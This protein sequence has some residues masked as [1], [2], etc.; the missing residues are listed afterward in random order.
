VGSPQQVLEKTLSFQEYFGSYQRQL[1]LIDHAGLPLKTVLNQL[2]LFGE[3]VLPELRKEMDSRAPK[4][5]TPAP[6]HAGLVAARDA[7]LEA[8]QA[9]TKEPVASDR[10]Q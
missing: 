5:L 1:F 3:Y 6:T 9:N 2:D 8:E 4:D 7:K 10:D